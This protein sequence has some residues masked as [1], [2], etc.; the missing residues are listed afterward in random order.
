MMQ[1]ETKFS[2]LICGH[3]CHDA[4][5]DVREKSMISG[6]RTTPAEPTHVCLFTVCFD[7]FERCSAHT[8]NF[9][10]MTESSRNMLTVI[11]IM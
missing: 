6:F 5:C 2:S 9:L 3:V 11:I 8:A 10:Q 7:C 1:K 4:G